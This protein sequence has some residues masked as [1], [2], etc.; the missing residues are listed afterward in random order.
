MD[1]LSPPARAA[2]ARTWTDGRPWEFLTRLTALG[3][4]MAGGQ[5]DAR[6]GDIVADAF[7]D[8][9]VERVA[10][11]PFEMAHWTRG[12]TTLELTAPDERSFE[13]IALPYS[14]PADVSGPLVDVGYGTPA[15][16]DDHDVDGAIVV[17]STTTPP[18]GRFVHRMEKF[19]YAIDS[20]AVAFVFVNHVPGQLPP[21]G[22]L[23]YDEEALA[24]A[25][26]VSNETGSWLRDYANRG[27]QARLTVDADTEP[28]ESRN[29]VGHLGP[30]TDRELVFCAHYDA[31]DIAEGALDNGCGIATVVTAA[32]ILAEM[33]LAL[34]VRVVGVGAE[35]LGLTG[36]EHL[37]ET[38]D[39]DR[40]AAVVNVDGAGRFRD[41][42]AMTHAS[43][44]TA[45]V[46]TRVADE[47]RHPIRVEP[48][49]HPFSDQWP[50]VRVGIPAVQLHSDSGERGRGWGHTHAD[51][52]DKVDDRN[53]REHAMLTALLVRELA[54]DAAD[55]TVPRLDDDE[56]AAA[57]RR[58]NFETGMK[59]AGI[60]P[61]GWNEG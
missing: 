51:T 42:V 25:V 58:E 61:D 50:F 4:R 45:E 34:G 1:D 26:G 53:I 37:V 18:G 20:G 7:A 22:A 44:A 15:E 13:T 24:P 41:L 33:D 16:I 60:W 9:G 52:R 30:D 46:A 3:D 21:T 40:V 2:F 55:G 5:G 29:V 8:A 47:T 54:A 6:A 11:D 39:L 56:L 28:G 27:G 14:P 36:A 23:R 48:E 32:R 10:F 38:L 17:A 59:A 35:E 19:N 49:P 43:E 31:H 12:E 57:F